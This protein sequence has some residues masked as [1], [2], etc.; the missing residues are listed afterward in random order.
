VKRL[1][2]SSDGW[3][4]LAGKGRASGVQYQRRK[5]VVISVI[6]A[7]RSAL[8]DNRIANPQ[9]M[10]DQKVGFRFHAENFSIWTTMR[11]KVQLA[12]VHA[13]V[14]LLSKFK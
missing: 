6:L 3:P 8:L 1:A 13:R 5:T 11:K 14:E 4:L 9:F 7:N 12:R 10:G 2:R